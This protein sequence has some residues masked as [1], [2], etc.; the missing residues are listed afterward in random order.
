MSAIAHHSSEQAAA[1]YLKRLNFRCW[2][3]SIA[4]NFTSSL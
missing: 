1:T 3:L 4:G 2:S